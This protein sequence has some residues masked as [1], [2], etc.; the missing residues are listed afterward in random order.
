MTNHPTPNIQLMNGRLVTTSLEVAGHF[1]KKHFNV[2]RD[3]GH[4]QK[5]VPEEWGQLNF[6]LSSYLNEQDKE[7]PCYTITRDGFALLAMGFTGREAMKWKV[8]F[9]ATFNRMERAL[10]I[11]RETYHDRIERT[12]FADHPR[13]EAVRDGL[14][15]GLPMESIMARTGYKHRSSIWRAAKSMERYG[16]LVRLEGQPKKYR[17][18]AP[19]KTIDL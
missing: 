13:W 1:G 14:D 11:G 4:I 9:L 3:I 19:F 16:I 2:L 17:W 8:R 10:R 6:E 18:Q 5:H 15:F 12:L 7:Q